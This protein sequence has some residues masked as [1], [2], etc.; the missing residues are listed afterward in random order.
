[1]LAV[2]L[3]TTAAVA[4]GDLSG[5]VTKADGTTIHDAFVSITNSTAS[6]AAL[7]DN[8]GHYVVGLP[9]GT[10]TAN[11]QAPVFAYG[12]AKFYGSTGAI[13]LNQPVVGLAAAP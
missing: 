8:S 3:G 13:K 11:V 5:A 9:N 7:T 10:Y 4:D 12:S 2:N 1:M 6:A